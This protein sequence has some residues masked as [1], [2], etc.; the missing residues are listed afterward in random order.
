MKNKKSYVYILTNQNNKVMY[1]GVTSNLV[2]RLQ[3]HISGTLGGFTARY[4][5]HKLVEYE[6]FTDIRDAIIRES[7][8]KN[9]KR[10]WKKELVSK[11]NPKWNDLGEDLL[12][13][14]VA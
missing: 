7:Q 11:A 9:W 5:V 10:S 14:P 4:N 12:Y 3:E 2:K 1:V 8:L 13:N 6:V